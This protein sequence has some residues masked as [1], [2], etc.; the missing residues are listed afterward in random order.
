MQVTLHQCDA[1]EWLRNTHTGVVDLVITDPPYE[2]LEKHRAKGTTTRLKKSKASS[3]EWFPVI[4]NDRLPELMRELYRVLKK[5][6]HC[7][8]FCDQETLFHLKP[9]GEAAGFTFWKPLVW[10][11]VHIGMGYHYRAAYEFV[12]FFEKGKRKLIDLGMSDVR[13]HA[14]NMK[15]D[16]YPA[17]KPQALLQELIRQ[18]AR[19]GE[20]VI[21][22]FF[23]GATIVRA[24]AAERCNFDGCDL[25][26]EAMVRGL[27]AL[28]TLPIEDRSSMDACLWY[29]DGRTLQSPIGGG[30]PLVSSGA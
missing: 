20:L 25:G 11:K 4:G 15:K 29:A 27:C 8:V 2:S 30:W 28:E 19:P 5:D 10:S 6:R 3:N 24:A 16:A 21:D 26:T 23:G 22:P 13:E 12:C 1:F 7:Y 14:R 18:S 9:A 17:E